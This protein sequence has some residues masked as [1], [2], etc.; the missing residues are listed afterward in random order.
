MEKERAESEQ[1][2][3]LLRKMYPR[4]FLRLDYDCPGVCLTTPMRLQRGRNQHNAGS[5]KRL[6]S[7][8]RMAPQGQR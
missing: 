4:N 8:T 7:E 1:G 3:K 5:G 2:E 6:S